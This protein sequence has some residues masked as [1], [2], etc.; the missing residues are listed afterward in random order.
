MHLLILGGTVFLGRHLA[1]AALAR[2]HQL[3]L[4]NRGQH[5][6]ELFP[7]AEKLLGDRG[8]PG[9]LE[10]LRGR[11]FDAVIDTCGY[12]PRI[13]GESATL[14]ANQVEQYCFISSISV[15]A[16]FKTPG[17]DE[18][19][20]VGQ[21]EDA[22]SEE[23]TGESYGPLKALCEEAVEAALPGRTLIVRPGLI[24]GPDDPTDRFAY[25]P[26]R[27]A[28]GGEALAPGTPET[29]TQFIDVRDLAD[30]NIRLL[31]RKTTGTYNA[32]GPDYP[33][34]L[35][36]V[37]KT[38]R[39]VSGS[40]TEWT[41]IEESF[42]EAEGVQ[43]WVEL[44]LWIPASSGMPGFDRVSIRKALEAGLTFRPLADTVRDTLAWTAIRPREGAWK[45]TLKPERERALIEKW[46][47]GK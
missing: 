20:P 46:R 28:Q 13:V 26:H 42:L 9:G 1:T 19:A 33:L 6:P 38:T 41:W 39:T 11:R 35:G 17:I 23:V 43:P 10:A 7:E 2:G 30:W 16:D 5:N 4:F 34:T 25:W 3:T 32:T 44:P 21:I 18:S 27:A 24:V 8:E 36:E 15:Y 22:A 45:N 29:R 40:S 14:L 31:E 47:A 37:L 12:V